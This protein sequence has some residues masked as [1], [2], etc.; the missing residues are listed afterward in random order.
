MGF[1]VFFHKGFFLA[2]ISVQ[3]LLFS[4]VFSSNFCTNSVLKCG[5]LAIFLLFCGNSE[6]QY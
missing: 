5:T 6:G 3:F 2:S 1:T 4:L